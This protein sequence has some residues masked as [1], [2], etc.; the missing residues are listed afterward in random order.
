MKKKNLLGILAV[1]MVIA[2]ALTGCGQKGE[3]NAGATGSESQ[4]EA[5]D[6]G[7]SS[8]DEIVE[9]EPENGGESP[10]DNT[11][12]NKSPTQDA[13]GNYIYTIT[14]DGVQTEVKTCINVWDYIT[15]D[16][17]YAWVDL[18]K[19]TEDL[20]YYSTGVID[21]IGYRFDRED[22][23]I[24]GVAG[25]YDSDDYNLSTGERR[26]YE[27][28]VQPT[29]GGYPIMFDAGDEELSC[30]D[31][32]WSKNVI[33]QE[34]FLIE[35]MDVYV[36]FDQI[37]IYAAMADYYRYNQVPLFRNSDRVDVNVP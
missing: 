33:S 32:V 13:D 23:V 27:L 4:N 12:S 8:A 25:T 7:N 36:S 17:P 1:L 21:M 11:S 18:L 16:T 24:V 3:Q 28:A 6:N 5:I 35:G 31:L 22:G 37:V 19:M 26:V 9:T 14:V 30:A 2:L 15:D 29:I 34:P 20:G 10:N